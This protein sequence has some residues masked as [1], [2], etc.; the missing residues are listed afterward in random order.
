MIQGAEWVVVWSRCL[1]CHG[2]ALA[3]AGNPVVVS[4]PTAAL[5]LYN[6]DLLVDHL[7]GK[8]FDLICGQ[9]QPRDC[10]PYMEPSY[11]I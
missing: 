7:L 3:K 9:M 8:P 1:A 4:L 6:L 10:Y 2:G 11:L 5:F